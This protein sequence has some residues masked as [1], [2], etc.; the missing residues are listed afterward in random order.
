[1]NLSL[2]LLLIRFLRNKIDLV[3]LGSI[4]FVVVHTSAPTTDVV[5]VIYS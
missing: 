4:T 3:L 5:E 2:S 1:M